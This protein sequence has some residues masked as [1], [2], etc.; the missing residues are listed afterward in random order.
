MDITWTTE[1]VENHWVV[2]L[3]FVSFN[4]AEQDQLAAFGPFTIDTGGSFGSG[5]SAFT[6]ATNEV[7]VPT[8]LPVRI[9]FSIDELTNAVAVARAATWEAA[10]RTRLQ[11]ALTAW[12]TPNPHV[13]QARKQETLIG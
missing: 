5:G 2:S 7:A 10:V 3:N 6:L 12:M 1:P 8:G 13:G 4:G 11:E 9:R